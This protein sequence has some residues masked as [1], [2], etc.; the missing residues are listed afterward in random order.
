MKDEVIGKFKKKYIPEEFDEHPD[1]VAP[2]ALQPNVIV[3]YKLN[4][5]I[6]DFWVLT[7][8]VNFCPTFN[9]APNKIHH[10]QL[11]TLQT[12]YDF[13]ETDNRIITYPVDQTHQL[14]LSFDDDFTFNSNQL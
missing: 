8:A 9:K 13:A 5:R 3:A 11:Q 2:V 7:I 14:Q 1:Y 12:V 6:R 4:T 10:F